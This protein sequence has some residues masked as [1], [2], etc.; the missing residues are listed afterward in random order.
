[1]EPE[2][3]KKT[4]KKP[5]PKDPVELLVE[6]CFEEGEESVLTSKR[7]IKKNLKKLIHFLKK[8]N[9]FLQYLS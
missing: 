6:I 3:Q 7:K 8:H 9:F 4:D 2:S 5:I 1:M